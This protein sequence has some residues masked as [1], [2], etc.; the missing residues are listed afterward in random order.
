MRYFWVLYTTDGV[1]AVDGIE[2]ESVSFERSG[3]IFLNSDS[4]GY[5]V[6]VVRAFA[7]GVWL[8]MQEVDA[9]RFTTNI[10]YPNW[11]GPITATRRENP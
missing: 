7:A 2:A 3:L 1:A 5:S 4:A 8:T 6:T 9:E 11:Q 10:V